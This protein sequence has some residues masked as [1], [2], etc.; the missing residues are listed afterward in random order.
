MPASLA[1]MVLIQVLL[2]ASAGRPGAPGEE[3]AATT[4]ELAE[5][6]GGITAYLRSPAKGLWTSPDGKTEHDDV[7][8]VEVVAEQFDRTWWRAY[9]TTLAARFDQESIHVRAFAVE[10]LDRDETATRPRMATA[11]VELKTV[12]LRRG[13][14]G[15]L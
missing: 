12:S 5:M 11:D 4:R 1:P 2:P 13:P 9:R 6:F 8:M 3:L 14:A 10:M 15:A 7:V